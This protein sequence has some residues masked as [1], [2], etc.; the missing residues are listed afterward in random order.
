MAL[1]SRYPNMTHKSTKKLPDSIVLRIR[2]LWEAG[3]TPTEIGVLVGVSAQ[4]VRNYT[5]EFEK[6]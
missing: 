2:R 5:R 6:V 1:L 3:Y 4:V